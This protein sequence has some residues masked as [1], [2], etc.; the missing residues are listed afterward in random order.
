MPEAADEMYWILS[1][2]TAFCST[3][4]ICHNLWA[5]VQ[6]A[7]CAHVC[8]ATEKPHTTTLIPR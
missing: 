2:G 4:S 5:N 1:I 8:P 3:P 7:K 6:F